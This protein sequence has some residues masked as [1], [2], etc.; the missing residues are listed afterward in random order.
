[1]FGLLR[2]LISPRLISNDKTN[3]T[4]AIAGNKRFVRDASVYGRVA[5]SKLSYNCDTPQLPRYLTA[6]CQGYDS[7]PD[8]LVATWLLKVGALTT[9]K[10]Y[11]IRVNVYLPRIAGIHVS[12]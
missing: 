12:K 8:D 5:A 7:L 6:T 3:L 2:G 4:W 11:G 1:M 9:V 10:P